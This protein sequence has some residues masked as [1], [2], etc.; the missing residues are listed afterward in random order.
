M[1]LNFKLFDNKQKCK[2]WGMAIFAFQKD[3]LDNYG[4]F[5]KYDLEDPL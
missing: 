2:V 5:K 4:V 1:I 3:A